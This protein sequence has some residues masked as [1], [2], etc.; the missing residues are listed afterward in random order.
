MQV[1]IE[2]RKILYGVVIANV[3]TLLMWDNKKNFE[4]E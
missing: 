3:S 1:N 2:K 4:E